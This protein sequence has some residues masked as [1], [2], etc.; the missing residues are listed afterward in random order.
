MTTPSATTAAPARPSLWRNRPFRTFW[1]GDTISQFG[2]RVSELALPLIAVL[3]LDASP[4][5][6]GLLTAA[7]WL[8][9]LIS[10][11]VGS[12]VDQRL[13]KRRL[14]IVADLVRAAALAS[15]PAAWALDALTFAHLYAVALVTGAAA[16]LFNTSYASFFVALVERADYLEANSKLSASRSASFIAGPAVGGGLIQVL[17]APV[18]VLVDVASFVASA[19]FI[20]RVKVP[21]VAIDP[22]D[23]PEPVWRRAVEGMRFVFRDRYLRAALGCATTVNFFTFMSAALIVLFASRELGLS[24]GVIGLAF[25]AGATGGLLGAVIA[26]RLSRRIGVGRNIVLGAVLFPLP[27]AI[28]GFAHG[29]HWW[30]ACLLGATEFLSGLGVMLFDVNLNS[31][32]ASVIPNELRSRVSGAFSSINYGV[33]PLGSVLGGTLGGLVGLRPTLVVAAV[34]GSLCVCWL[35][36]S[37]IPRIHTLTD[38]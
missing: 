8:P 2:D 20:S 27:I 29:P 21:D 13:H 37:P 19:L 32:M 23:G 34:G 6:V 31:V 26:P 36:A 28:L 15:V 25:G 16:V 11:F 4:G 9:N 5:Q 17:T 1:V 12:W 30:T 38:L 35:F 33:R 22:G 14:M 10:L 3:Q 7:V 24:P 18:T